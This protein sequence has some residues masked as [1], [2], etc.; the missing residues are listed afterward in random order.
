MIKIEFVLLL[1]LDLVLLLTLEVIYIGYDI[2]SHYD[3]SISNVLGTITIILSSCSPPPTPTL[4][5]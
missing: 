2:I 5:L 3:S 1:I 4:A